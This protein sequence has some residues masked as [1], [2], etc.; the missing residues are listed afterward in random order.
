[1]CSLFPT[2]V[3]RTIQLPPLRGKKLIKEGPR[4]E[5]EGIVWKAE[6]QRCGWVSATYAAL[7]VT[8]AVASAHQQQAHAISLTE[9]S[10]ECNNPDCGWV[11]PV[12]ECVTPKHIPEMILCPECHETT[13]PV[14]SSPTPPEGARDA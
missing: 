11:G 4:M 8:Q 1:M 9:E 5:I 2:A 7:N 13:E 10:R 6:C 14:R 3:L 12:A